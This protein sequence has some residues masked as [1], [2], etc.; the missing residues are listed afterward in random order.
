MEPHSSTGA[1]GPRLAE[2]PSHGYFGLDVR[3]GCRP[4]QSPPGRACF[5]RPHFRSQ[6]AGSC[7]SSRP[8]GFHGCSIRLPVCWM[9]ISSRR[10]HTSNKNR[11]PGFSTRSASRNA[12]CFS[13]KTMTPN[14]VASKAESSKAQPE[15]ISLLPPDAFRT[16]VR[17]S[18]VEYSP[19]QASR[20]FHRYC[21][22]LSFQR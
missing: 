2:P 20:D 16:G 9:T 17:L 5:P 3:I 12:V 19:I 13:G 18:T 6:R 8:G 7:I 1:I 11:P 10:S 22:R 14:T 15:R 4:S 21:R